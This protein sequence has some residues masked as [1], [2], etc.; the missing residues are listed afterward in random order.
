MDQRSGRLAEGSI[1]SSESN[2]NKEQVADSNRDAEPAD[3]LDGVGTNSREDK[4]SNDSEGGTSNRETQQNV[5]DV[6]QNV[7]E[8][9][10]TCHSGSWRLRLSNRRNEQRRNEEQ[11]YGLHVGQ[12]NDRLGLAG[13]TEKRR[14]SSSTSVSTHL[15][16]DFSY[17]WQEGRPFNFRVPF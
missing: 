8:P 1:L 5:G 6:R 16:P 12:V 7:R 4:E 15:L 3:Q 17:F 2:D 10:L 9:L 13:L 14:R 11:R